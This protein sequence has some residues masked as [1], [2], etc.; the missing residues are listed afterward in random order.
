[1]ITRETLPGSRGPQRRFQFAEKVTH[2]RSPEFRKQLAR[3]YRDLGVNDQSDSHE[4]CVDVLRVA[5]RLGLTVVHDAGLKAV[6]RISTTLDGRRIIHIPVASEHARF[7]IAHEVAHELLR[8]G[9]LCPMGIDPRQMDDIEEEFCNFVA[10]LLLMPLPQFVLRVDALAAAFPDVSFKAYMR[11][12]NAFKV[13]LQSLLV[14]MSILRRVHILFEWVDFSLSQVKTQ[15]GVSVLL[16]Y[17]FDWD[18]PRRLVWYEGSGSMLRL[19][20]EV[21]SASYRVLRDNS[22]LQPMLVPIPHSVRSGLQDIPQ[23]VLRVE[24]CSLRSQAVVRHLLLPIQE[25]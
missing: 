19:R 15:S 21:A 1:M 8:C 18:F 6:G 10:G 24:R 13:S 23:R 2:L 4:P 12:A 25:S 16:A 3:V 9:S 5:S 22:S 20:K 14:Q 7:V 17:T 11:M